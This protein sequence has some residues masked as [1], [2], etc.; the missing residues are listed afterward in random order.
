MTVRCSSPGR[1]FRLAP[2]LAVM[3]VLVAGTV[4]GQTVTVSVQDVCANPGAAAIQVPIALDSA[5]A[6]RALSFSLQ[7]SPDELQLTSG[8]TAATCTDR[9]GGFTCSANEV[10]ATNLI[11]ALVISL[12]GDNVAAG[13]GPV[14]ILEFTDGPVACTPGEQVALELSNAMVAGSSDGT[15]P[16]IASN[17]TFTCGCEPTTTSSTST[18]TTTSVTTSS[19]TTSTTTTSSST[20][21]T[22]S[23]TTTTT[24][25]TAT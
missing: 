9:T 17:G 3:S 18:T 15:V 21:V 24:T 4:S 12:A 19:S 10:T 25:T 14:V 2:V 11:N 20:T 13:T 6:V 8:R 1:G 23:S 22:S 7:D 16:T 5:V